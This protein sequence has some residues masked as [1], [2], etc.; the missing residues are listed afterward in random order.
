MLYFLYSLFL[1]LCSLF[2]VP[3]SLLLLIRCSF[4]CVHMRSWLK[5][6]IF[7]TLRLSRV[8]GRRSTA[9]RVLS[10]MRGEDYSSRRTYHSGANLCY[11]SLQVCHCV[12]W[13][14]RDARDG[15]FSQT[16][17]CRRFITGNC[18][19]KKHSSQCNHSSRHRARDSPPK[20]PPVRPPAH[21]PSFSRT[22][23]ANVT[24]RWTPTV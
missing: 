4:V 24:T 10:V 8:S 21:D 2:F 16:H 15:S 9:T 13:V 19:Y 6:L 23:L 12:Q 1:I 11:I 18:I 20:T 17:S 3:H 5:L 22:Y 14:T 7:L